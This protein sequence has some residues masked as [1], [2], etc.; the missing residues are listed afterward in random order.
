MH[1]IYSHAVQ[2]ATAYKE[3]RDPLELAIFTIHSA[4]NTTIYCLL[5]SFN[6]G[7]KWMW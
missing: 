6:E 4:Y 7:E 5:P 2:N 1:S 3:V